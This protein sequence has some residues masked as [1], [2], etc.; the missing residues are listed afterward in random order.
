MMQIE[1]YTFGKIIVDGQVYKSDVIITPE[2][3]IDSWWRKQGHRLDKSDLNE[4][5]GA[6]PD[7]L[8]VGTGY[9]GRMNIP[10]ETIQYLQ[11][12]NIQLNYAPTGDAIKQ[13][14]HLQQRCSRIVAALHLTC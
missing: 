3:V 13:L 9:Y 7:C 14:R 4:I 1:D 10:N 11:S 8:L 5:L 6:N 12:I 2:T